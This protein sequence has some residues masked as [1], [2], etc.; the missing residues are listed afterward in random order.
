MLFKLIFS[1]ILESEDLWVTAQMDQC[2][3]MMQ[4]DKICSLGQRLQLAASVVSIK[5][6]FNIFM[7]L[8]AILENYS[9][10]HIREN[11]CSDLLLNKSFEIKGLQT[12]TKR[13]EN[14]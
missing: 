2:E 14:Q 7:D 8:K 9:C 11:D 3:R 5:L 13:Q 4:C 6:Q 1:L 12:S 10:I